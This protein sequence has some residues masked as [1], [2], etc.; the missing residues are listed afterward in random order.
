MTDKLDGRCTFKPIFR[1]ISRNNSNNIKHKTN[2]NFVVIISPCC[3]WRKWYIT[4]FFKLQV[5]SD[6]APPFFRTCVPGTSRRCLHLVLVEGN[7]RQLSQREEKDVSRNAVDSRRPCKSRNQLSK[8][9]LEALL[10]G[11]HKHCTDVTALE[12]QKGRVPL[13]FRGLRR[14]QEHSC[15]SGSRAVKVT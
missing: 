10:S 14:T 2:M 8:D 15:D 4:T 12:H 9:S 3:S 7:P 1:D 13:T 6:F 5:S 11:G